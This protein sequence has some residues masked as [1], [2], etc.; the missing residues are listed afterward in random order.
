MAKGSLRQ[1]NP[2]RGSLQPLLAPGAQRAQ[3]M[4]K[5]AGCE[6]LPVPASRPHCP[7]FGCTRG[8]GIRA[9]KKPGGRATCHLDTASP[10]AG[11]WHPTGDPTAQDGAPPSDSAP[12]GRCAGGCTFNGGVIAKT[13]LWQR[14]RERGEKGASWSP[15]GTRIVP[16]AL[17][18]PWGAAGG[19]QAVWTLE[20]R[21]PKALQPLCQGQGT[22]KR[23]RLCLH[24]V[25]ALPAVGERAAACA[26]SAGSASPPCIAAASCLRRVGGC[27]PSPHGG[28][29]PPLANAGSSRSCPVGEM[30]CSNA[31]RQAG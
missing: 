18:R 12:R 30:S 25:R 8:A 17:P 1:E 31:Q 16:L 4:C 10:W 22:A 29:R 28:Q 19:M 27:V 7:L 20:H 15:R 14:Q 13:K 2:H 6:Q 23:G 21:W 9:T 3:P 5:Q 11:A 26:R 24:G